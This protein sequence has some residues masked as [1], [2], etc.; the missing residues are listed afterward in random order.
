MFWGCFHGTIKGSSVFWEKNWGHIIMKSY[1][2]HIIPVLDNWLQ[3]HCGLRFMQDGA[4][5][6]RGG[7]TQTEIKQH[8]MSMIS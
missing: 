7:E 1:I 8:N 3:Q 6:H 4:P 5:G 2:E